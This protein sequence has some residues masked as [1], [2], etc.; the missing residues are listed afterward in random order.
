ME[1]MRVRMGLTLIAIGLFSGALTAEERATDFLQALRDKGYYDAALVYLDRMESSSLADGEFREKISY[2]RGI[3][4]V[5]AAAV[6]TSTTLREQKFNEARTSL[7][8]FVKQHPNHAYTVTAR[9]QFGSMLMLWARQKLDDAQRLNQPELRGQAAKLYDQAIAV[10]SKAI[11]NLKTSLATLKKNA[12]MTESAEQLDLRKRLRNEYLEAQVLAVQCLEEKADTFD[13]GSKQRKV[14][15][16]QAA[17]KYATIYNKYSEGSRLAAF[18]ARL[19]QCR[20]LIGVGDD[21]K[22][23]DYLVNDLLSQDSSNPAFRTMKTKAM[24]LA[25][26]CWTDASKKDFQTA[27]TRGRAWLDTIRPDETSKP[28]W[29][30]LQLKLAKAYR[31]LGKML[32][33]KNPKDERVKEAFGEAVELARKL[34]KTS[35]PY[36]SEARS[37]LAELPQGIRVAQ[38]PSMVVAKTFEQAR[39]AGQEA[40]AS[41]RSAQFVL[42]NV[43]KRLQ[44]EKDAE[45]KKELQA[46]LQEARET[47]KQRQLDAI[48]YFRRALQLV[49]SDTPLE[50][51]NFTYYSLAYLSY[52]RADYYD[53]AVYGEF[54]A[55]RFPDAPLASRAAQIVLAAYLKLYEL[56]ADDDR[57]FETA[58]VVSIANYIVD[59][60]AGQPEAA[61][62]V[63]TLIPFLIRQG[64]LDKAREYLDRISPDSAERGAAEL[65]VGQAM[66]RAY[67]IGAGE[68]RKLEADAAGTNPPDPELAT[69]IQQRKQEL[70][71][72]KDSAFSILEAGVEHNKKASEIDPTA[73]MAVLALAQAYI[74][75]D[76]AE[77]AVSLLDDPKIGTLALVQ[78]SDPLAKNPQLIEQT[79]KTA[80]SALVGALPRAAS[81]DQRAKLIDR[82]RQTMRALKEQVGQD[83][84]AQKRLLAIFFS[85]ARGLERQIGLIDDPVERQSLAEGFSAFLTEV[86][87][88]ATDVSVLNWVAQSYVSLGNALLSDKQ[89]TTAAKKY[90]DLAVESFDTILK[91][92]T[93]LKLPVKTSY[94]IQ[95]YMTNALRSAGRY[96]EATRML[97]KVL[98]AANRK[99]VIQVEAAQTYQQWA[100]QPGQ[101]ARYLDAARGAIVDPKTKQNI[102][103]GWAQIAKKTQPYDQ[104]R[105][106]FHRAR[107]NQALCYFKYGMRQ[108]DKGLQSKYLTLAEKTIVFTEKLYPAMGGKEW[109]TKYDNLLRQVQRSRNKRVTGLS[110]RS[111]VGKSR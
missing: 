96:E 17:D 39:S 31:M 87:S 104:F 65:R 70:Q 6:E 50:D 10:F 98:A 63:N 105:S 77:K 90:Y 49:D 48:Q 15:L 76:Q 64:Q 67:L 14:L 72:L 107:Y 36:Q 19:Y 73:P 43:P 108:R 5:Q 100:E 42:E 93:E 27:T 86:R 33:A 55:R 38:T 16:K 1:N 85:M 54:V 32:K 45:T 21:D 58:H 97:G 26:D 68:L 102:I 99:V 82:A 13:K 46:A 41:I 34:A 37:L 8:Q 35:S 80:L 25:V 84:K 88:E 47:V 83:A 57:T 101:D 4:L 44:R 29:L 53:S 9:R 71:K 11:A 94:Q 60:W 62:A 24:L 81:A 111:S 106:M 61:T 23:L 52:L 91:R 110:A 75:A 79:Y 56:S 20:A 103:W 95:V 51:L 59:T 7:E 89:T 40:Q 92:S 74:D 22:A 28:D 18:Y 2:E 12:G 69:R 3:T 78:R 109:R 66:W 30:L